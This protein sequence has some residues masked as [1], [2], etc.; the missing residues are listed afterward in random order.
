MRTAPPAGSL[1]G[2]EEREGWTPSDAAIL[3]AARS[4]RGRNGTQVCQRG[5]KGSPAL[6]VPSRVWGPKSSAKGKR[7]NWEVLSEA[8][9]RVRVWGQ[10]GDL[11][12]DTWLKARPTLP[13]TSQVR[14][15]AP[16]LCRHSHALVSRALGHA[17]T[18]ALSAE[19]P[20]LSHQYVS[21]RSTMGNG[22]FCPA[23]LGPDTHLRMRSWLDICGRHWSSYRFLL[24][25][26]RM[27]DW[28]LGG[29]EN[30]TNKPWNKARSSE[31][32]GGSALTGFLVHILRNKTGSAGCDYPLG[33]AVGGGGQ[34]NPPPWEKST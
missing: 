3:R 9:R 21:D 12:N 25:G 6:L 11:L 24:K 15:Q 13:L 33:P 30:Q 31:E 34:D 22:C 8:G 29:E 4:E 1:W 14:P 23:P 32:E 28:R 7:C 19:W 26:V 2:D 5:H 20:A 17:I 16:A 18:R 10:W 27:E